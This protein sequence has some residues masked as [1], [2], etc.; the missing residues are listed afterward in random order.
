MSVVK[1][2]YSFRDD[3][4]EGCHEDILKALLTTNRS[5]QTAYGDDEYCSKARAAIRRHL[6]NDAAEI[7]FLSTGTQTNVVAIASLLRPFESVIATDA[8]HIHTHEAGGLEAKGFKIHTVGS[9]GSRG[10]VTVKQVEEV[11]EQHSGVHMVRPR[12]VYISN[13]TEMGTVYSKQ[14]LRELKQVCEANDLLL[15]MDGA[16]LGAA[17]ASPGNDVALSDLKE[18]VDC[19]WIGGTKNGALCGEAMVFNSG[20]ICRGF[21]HLLKQS[22]ALVAK[23]RIFGVQF[24]ALFE[25]DLFVELAR[26][27]IERAQELAQGLEALGVELS[28]PC[29]TNQIFPLLPCEVVDELAKKFMFYVWEK[30]EGKQCVIRLVTSWATP[31]SAVEQFLME[32]KLAIEPY[33]IKN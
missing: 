10:K 4:S 30:G 26:S 2:L 22:G 20:E 3:Y 19:F 8:S 14:E 28:V 9:K 33:C 27:A 32:L 1:E 29:E 11:V 18:L 15:F 21:P 16:R 13:A 25:E 31:K 23:G 7:F 6:Q 12:L 5:Q 24:L 17:L